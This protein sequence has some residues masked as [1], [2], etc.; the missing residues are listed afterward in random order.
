MAKRKI[1][2][3]GIQKFPKK[4]QEIVFG[5]SS[6]SQKTIPDVTLELYDTFTF[7]L[8]TVDNLNSQLQ[9]GCFFYDKPIIGTE[10]HYQIGCEFSTKYSYK[11]LLFRLNSSKE[12]LGE[13]YIKLYDKETKEILDSS[14]FKPSTFQGYYLYYIQY[15]IEVDSWNFIKLN[16][17]EQNQPPQLLGT[18][19]PT[20]SVSKSMF[21]MSNDSISKKKSQK[22]VSRNT[23]Q[24]DFVVMPLTLNLKIIKGNDLAIQDL[25]GFSD[26]YCK[27]YAANQKLKTSVIQKVINQSKKKKIY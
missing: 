8:D 25:N 12:N 13:I 26:P 7:Y 20:K 14:N 9:E 19:S 21:I 1:E 5:I 18:K 22:V 4:T 15:N 23:I 24:L 3:L 11:H 27:V 16:E 10:D 17:E 6:N 2:S